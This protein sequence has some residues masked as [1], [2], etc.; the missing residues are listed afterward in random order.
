MILTIEFEQTKITL[1]VG[2]GGV[3]VDAPDYMEQETRQT[4]L[5]EA[6]WAAYAQGREDERNAIQSRLVNAEREARETMG[7]PLETLLKEEFPR[8]DELVETTSAIT[9]DEQ[10][11]KV[12]PVT[13]DIAGWVKTYRAERRKRALEAQPRAVCVSSCCGTEGARTRDGSCWGCR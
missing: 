2:P 1:S 3:T 7:E 11:P 12:N 8:F 9:E 10:P 4:T 6:Q 13:G 5:S